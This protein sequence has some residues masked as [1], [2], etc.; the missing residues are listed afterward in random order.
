MQDLAKLSD[1]AEAEIGAL[2]AEGITLSPA[3]IVTINALAWAVESP[4]SRM[5]LSRGVP[6]FVGGITLWPLTMCGWDWYRRVG[7]KLLGQQAQSLALAYAMAHGRTEGALDMGRALA[8]L[9]VSAFGVRLGFRA[10]ELIEAIAQV[11]QQD[12]QHEGPP[13]PDGHSMTPGELSAFL[14]AETGTAPDVWERLVS[15]GYVFQ[16]LTTIVQ[17]NKADGKPTAADPKIRATVALEWFCQQIRQ[18][19]KQ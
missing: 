13:T 1:L 8:E 3:D 2:V 6:V 7:C 9:A 19:G 14:A 4:E 17:Q 12:E 16:M 15:M 10:S 5:A 18:R 11:L